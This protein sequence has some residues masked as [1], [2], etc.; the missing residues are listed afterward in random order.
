LA[1]F[2]LETSI[3][4]PYPPEAVWA[5]LTDFASFPGWNPLVIQ[6]S[7]L[8]SL[9]AT[10]TIRV[11]DP[12]GTG[13]VIPFR[14]KVTS[15]EPGRHLAWTGRLLVPG[16]FDG[17]HWYRLEPTAGGTRFRHGEHFGGLILRL[18]GPSTVAA[19]RPGY[20]AMNQALAGEVARRAATA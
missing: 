2:D 9:G 18:M 5:V 10:L 13:Q 14:P 19:M 15:L 16:L 7:G 20:E 6:A 17:E 11:R 1:G 4:I 3:D 12:R 8:L